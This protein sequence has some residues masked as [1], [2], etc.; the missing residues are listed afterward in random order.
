MLFFNPFFFLSS[1]N[2]MM[3]MI[4]MMMMMSMMMTTTTTMVSLVCWFTKSILGLAV[5]RDA[6]GG[7]Y[8]M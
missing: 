8:T 5:S 7:Y 6:V 4:I 3:T 1:F 2:M